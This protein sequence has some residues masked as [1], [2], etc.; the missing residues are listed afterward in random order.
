MSL[1]FKSSE[2]TLI[3]LTYTVSRSTDGLHVHRKKNIA[4]SVLINYFYKYLILLEISLKSLVEKKTFLL[5][6]LNPINYSL[7]ELSIV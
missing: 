2:F 4:K 3:P 6:A 5:Q 1:F 7:L